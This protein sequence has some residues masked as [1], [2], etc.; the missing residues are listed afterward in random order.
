MAARVPQLPRLSAAA[1]LLAAGAGVGA[2]TLAGRMGDKALLVVDGRTQVVAPG[3]SVAGLRVLGWEGE[4]LRVERGGQPMLLRPG[5]APSVGPAASAPQG[6]EVVIPAGSG[7]HFVVAGSINGRATRFLVDTG[8]TSV[9]LSRAEADR[10]GLDTSGAP[11]GLASTAGG[12]VQV[13]Q[14]TLARLRLGEVELVNVPAVV[15]PTPMPYVLL[16][17]SALSRMRMQRET[18]VMRLQLR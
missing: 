17:H 6:R 16:G 18:D 4:A 5:A 15:T 12:V 8:A 2:Q 3:Q 13:Q 7:G 9:A 1:L 10:I 14:V 11:V